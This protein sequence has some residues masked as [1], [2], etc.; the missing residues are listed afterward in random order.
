MTFLYRVYGLH[1]SQ[2]ISFILPQ[3]IEPFEIGV[4]KQVDIKLIEKKL[5]EG[6]KIIFYSPYH[7]LENVYYLISPQETFVL[8]QDEYY[9]K[10]D[11]SLGNKDFTHTDYLLVPYLFTL[12]RKLKQRQRTREFVKLLY[13]SSVEE[14][15]QTNHPCEAELFVSKLDQIETSEDLFWCNGF[16]KNIIQEEREGA[17]DQ[18]KNSYA[19]GGK[20]YM[21]AKTEFMREQCLKR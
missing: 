19:P 20:G 11:E 3:P 10:I 18:I 12:L 5:K 14:A 21:Y 6:Q 2:Q 1:T 8:E 4:N 13:N 7:K 17:F 15:Q 9:R 16:D